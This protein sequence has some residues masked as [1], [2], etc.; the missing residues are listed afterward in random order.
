MTRTE[1]DRMDRRILEA[2]QAEG[3]LSNV[4]L[5]DRVALSPSP[6][7]RRVKRLED[8]G[9]IAGYRAVVDRAKVGLGLTVF[10]EIKA[11]KHSRE[12]AANLSR[13]IADMPEVV[14]CHIVSGTADFLAEIVVP[15]LA[16]YE[17]FMLDRLLAL[18]TVEDVRSYFAIRTLKTAAPLPLGHLG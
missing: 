9:V 6:C 15:D 13:G 4:E 12:N 18:P 16:A 17:H 10:V 14:S 2:L 1:I 3:R 11:G 8:D 5:A 7:L